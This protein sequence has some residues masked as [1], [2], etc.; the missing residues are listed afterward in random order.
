MITAK[1]AQELLDGATPGPWRLDRKDME[2]E[3]CITQRIPTRN[4][5]LVLAA[6][7]LAETVIALTERL[8]RAENHIED[9][10]DVY[11]HWH[12]TARDD[13]GEVL[14]HYRQFWRHGS[15]RS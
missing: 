13:V 6:P 10:F 5:Q 12:E 9:V 7:D 1:Q 2:D 8:E 11:N 4:V 15:G 14:R 3:E